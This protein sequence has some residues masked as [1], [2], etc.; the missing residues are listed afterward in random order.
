MVVYFYTER[1]YG[2]QLA[3]AEDNETVS[4]LPLI[5]WGSELIRS[6]SEAMGRSSFWH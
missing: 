3:A 2:E 6:V 5:D 4:S 1:Y